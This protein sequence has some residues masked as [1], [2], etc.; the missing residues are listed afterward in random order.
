MTPISIL[1]AD[2]A[3]LMQKGAILIDVREA[4]ERRRLHIAASV[5][6]PLSSSDGRVTAS[7]D[8]IF[9]C[10]SGAR[11]QTNASRLAAQTTG[12]SFLLEGG[13]A[14]WQKAGLPVIED[15]SQPIDIM[16][17]VMIVAGSLVLIGV[18]LGAFL[19]PIFYGLAGFVGAGLLFS[20][21]TGFC[22]MAKMLALAPWNKIRI[23]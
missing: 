17:Q 16:R 6:Q 23:A 4:S 12:Q 20:G 8:M 22:A 10:A 11:T 2:A 7:A 3:T 19:N 5:H 14:A 18:L 1:P 21:A 13:I 15:K 9:H